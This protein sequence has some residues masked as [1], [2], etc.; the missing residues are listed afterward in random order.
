MKTEDTISERLR[1]ARLTDETRAALRE[2]KPLVA[3][4]LPEIMKHFYAHLR[5]WPEVARFFTSEG[6]IDGAARKQGE[7]WGYIL[8][9][10][11]GSRY[12]ESVKRIGLT[13]AR[14]GLEPRWYVAGYSIIVEELSEK[15][16]VHCYQK[17]KGGGAARERLFARLNGAF[18]RAAM[19][20]MELVTSVY[21]EVGE[22]AKKRAIFI[23]DAAARFGASVDELVTFVASAAHELE[24]TA[25]AMSK[26]AESTTGKAIAVSA[27]AEQATSNVNVVANS[28]DEM[29]ASVQEIA[30]QVGQASRV[31]A[32]AV[33]KARETGA[34]MDE[35][36]TSAD[37]IGEVVSLISSIAGQTNLLALN[38][39]IESARAGEAGRGFA[40]VAAEV[41]SLAGQTAKATEQIAAQIGAM[42]TIARRS[43][44]SIASIQATINEI[45]TVSMAITTAV[46]EQ[47]ATTQEIAR[48]TREAAM[49]TQDVTRNIMDVQRDA[50][51]AGT[52]AGQVVEASTELGKRAIELRQQ[53]S[54]FVAS[55]QAA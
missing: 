5:K 29:G 10:D 25:R 53:V 21:L 48:N 39:T 22:A 37:R 4:A 51:D 49:G 52:A 32:S 23:A 45:D 26:T 41:K 43:V 31:A 24:Q 40:V 18:L 33:V 16:A 35:L 27:A 2:L 46:E 47:T 54:Q 9:G 3:T 7:H 20:D 28:A 19:L 36:A 17:S 6:M 42:Q 15:I 13:H 55:I 44:E 14:I 1:F 8:E 11:F 12:Q 30:N 34:T 38:A 50:S